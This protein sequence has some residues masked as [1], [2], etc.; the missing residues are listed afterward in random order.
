MK[1]QYLIK[2]F[3]I[4]TWFLNRTIEKDNNEIKK[5]RQKRKDLKTAMRKLDEANKQVYKDRQLAERIKANVAKI[6]E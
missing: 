2:F 4:L 6:T 1:I 3:D 5:N